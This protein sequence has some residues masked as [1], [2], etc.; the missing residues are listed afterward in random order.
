MET[1]IGDRL[2]TEGWVVRTGKETT[3]YGTTGYVVCLL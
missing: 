3:D 1:E 2:S